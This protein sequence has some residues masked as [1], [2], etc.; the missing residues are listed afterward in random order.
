[1]LLHYYPLNNEITEEY[2]DI[3]SRYTLNDVPFSEGILKFDDI[4]HELLLEQLKDYVLKDITTSTCYYIALEKQKAD[5]DV[6][7]FHAEH[8]IVKQSSFWEHLFQILNTYLELHMVPAKRLISQEDE[9][10]KVTNFL[11]IKKLRLKSYKLNST[12]EQQI[13]PKVSFLSRINIIQKTRK[14][15]IN[16]IHLRPLVNIS[17]QQHWS[18]L[19]DLRNDIIHYKFLRQRGVVNLVE[20]DATGILFTP[21]DQTVDHTIIGVLLN[22]CLA[23]IY[24]SIELS[25][26]FIR[27][28]LVPRRKDSTQ[29]EFI[30]IKVLCK[31]EEE[32]PYLIPKIFV[33]L[34]NNLGDSPYRGI[35]CPDCFSDNLVITEEEH[36]VSE[37]TYK[38][39]IGYYIGTKMQS[40]MEKKTKELEDNT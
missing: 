25:T 11:N 1:M 30:M 2:N 40:Y 29:T 6:L 31:N 10:W 20:K 19:R 27:Q 7:C 28:D 32:K 4:I 13:K 14:M 35:F 22:K 37:K 12:L 15:F 17:N 34:N 24:T 36:H 23:D 18:T 26:K 8:A 21:H 33:D 39:A 38:Q 3:L 5:F 16:D 9:K